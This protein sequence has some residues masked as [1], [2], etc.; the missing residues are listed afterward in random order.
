[1]NSLA[2]DHAPPAPEVLLMG[3]IAAGED[4]AARE[5]LA[6]NL[7]ALY[8]FVRHALGRAEGAEDVV[9]ATLVRAY[10]AAGRFDGR[11]SLRTWLF[12]I[13]WR[14]VGRWRRRRA[15]LPI[16]GD[17]GAL[18]PGIAAVEQ[19]AWVEAALAVLTPPLRT[20]FALVHV[21]EISIAEAAEILEIPEGTVKS[22]VHAA[23]A[24][25]RTYLEKQDA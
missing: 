12:A 25:L 6:V 2:L 22:R 20:A 18:S 1:M 11:A 19:D 14:E 15:W 13:A 8:R 3:R 9:Q 17:R 4:A 10:A 23:K 24:R 21:E 5:M 16:I 7:D